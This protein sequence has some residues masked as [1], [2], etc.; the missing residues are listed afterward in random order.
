M[1]VMG[2]PAGSLFRCC[3]ALMKEALVVSQHRYSLHADS[4]CLRV[5]KPCV[6]C[7]HEAFVLLFLLQTH[8][9]NSKINIVQL[10]VI[11]VNFVRKFCF[12]LLNN[13]LLS[14]SLIRLKSPFGDLSVAGAYPTTHCLVNV[15]YSLDGLSVCHREYLTS[16]LFRFISAMFTEPMKHDTGK[17]PTPLCSSSRMKFISLKLCT[18][19]LPN[20]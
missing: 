12:S 16:H 14:S 9:Y 3:V 6:F 2:K 10:L 20:S 5:M 4:C 7:K 11:R 1:E 13:G 17:K 15:G 19:S 18:S 8:Y